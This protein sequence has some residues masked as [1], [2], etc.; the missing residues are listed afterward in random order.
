MNPMSHKMSLSIILLFCTLFF[1]CVDDTSD[2][3]IQYDSVTY[4]ESDSIFLNPERGFYAHNEYSSSG[5]NYF[6]ESAAKV[7]RESGR[8]IALL[9]FYMQDFRNS[10]ISPEFL[11]RVDKSLKNV[12]IGGC[13]TVLRFAYTDSESDTPWDASQ[14]LVL[15]HIEQL[16]P[17]L[18][19]YSDVIF[20]MEAGFVGVW[21][22]WYYTDH[23]NFEP[24]TASDYAPRRAVLDAL[25]KALPE[26]RMICVR[27]P[28]FKLNCFG[29]TTADTI[30]AATAYNGS[31]L[32]R[33]A[34]HDDA[35]LS[36]SSDMGTFNGTADK[37]FWYSETKYTVMGGETDLKSTYSDYTVA[38]AAMEKLHLTY[39]NADYIN[40]VLSNWTSGGIM[41]EIKRRMGYRFVL[42]D[43]KFTQKA[44]AGQKYEVQLNIKN[45]GFAATVNSRDVELLFILKEDSATKYK[46]KLSNDPRFWFANGK[47]T[48]NTTFG[49]PETMPVGKYDVYLN[50]PDPESNLSARPEYS[51]RLANIGVW[52]ATLGY[53]KINTMTVTKSDDASTYDGTFLIKF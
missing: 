48:I 45:V 25:L 38:I 34:C 26:K 17:Y 36:T 3:S 41:P 13:K 11:E 32:S 6:T 21:G 9:I 33:I 20:A 23:F 39:L 37:N 44:E 51:I 43:G 50:L 53:N 42:T 29:I 19:E 14:E 46:I 4:T 15:Q 47:Y 10:L 31:D 12:R 5:T 27:T 7:C 52:N 8:S 30:T 24:Q 18:I 35:F 28:A 49:L 40:T 1:S 22:E 16:K 2:D